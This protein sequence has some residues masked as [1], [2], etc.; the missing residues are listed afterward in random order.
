MPSLDAESR[1]QFKAVVE[2]LIID[3]AADAEVLA[4]FGFGGVFG[5]QPAKRGTLQGIVS[6][7]VAFVI[8]CQH[9]C[10]FE[11]ADMILQAFQI[12]KYALLDILLCAPRLRDF[13]LKR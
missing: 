2:I 6:R 10:E 12:F 4:R 5:A 3:D 13:V 7:N 1:Q 9:L 11:A 8:L